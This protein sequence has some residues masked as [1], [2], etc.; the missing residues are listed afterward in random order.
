MGQERF[1][2]HTDTRLPPGCNEC[3]ESKAGEALPT[4]AASVSSL[5][6]ETRQVKVGDMGFARPISDFANMTQA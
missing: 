6:V 4:V 1:F 5:N 2:P 3:D